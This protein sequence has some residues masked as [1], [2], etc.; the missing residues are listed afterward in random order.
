MAGG[1]SLNI[2]PSQYSNCI[3]HNLDNRDTPS[4]AARG[5]K[6][7]CS[8][9]RF[10]RVWGLLQGKIKQLLLLKLSRSCCPAQK[11]SFSPPLTIGVEAA[12]GIRQYKYFKA[13]FRISFLACSM[14]SARL[15]YSAKDLVIGRHTARLHSCL[16]F[17]SPI[18]HLIQHN[19]RSYSTAFGED[20]EHRPSAS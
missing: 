13:N 2:A 8:C 6:L 10:L 14:L 12:R 5:M 19:C 3:L 17:Q 4:D 15:C 11:V 1:E 7:Q 9:S 18:Q 16:N 20:L